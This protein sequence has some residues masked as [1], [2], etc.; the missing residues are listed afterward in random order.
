MTLAK[1][2]EQYDAKRGDEPAFDD[3]SPDAQTAILTAAVLA[4]RAKRK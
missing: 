2:R 1:A 4:E 3:L